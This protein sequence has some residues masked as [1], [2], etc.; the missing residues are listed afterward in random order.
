MIEDWLKRIEEKLDALIDR[1]T[2]KPFY[3]IEEASRRLNKAE[4][5]VR[6]WA[7][8]G[9]I[10][11]EKKRSGRGSHFSWVVS[12]EEINRIEREGLLPFKPR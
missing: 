2:V 7:R 12:A 1:D 4:F 5:T 8:L 10:K 11:A 3:S 6:E 9:R